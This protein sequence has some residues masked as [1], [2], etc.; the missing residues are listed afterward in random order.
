MP[1][2][3]ANH[4]EGVIMEIADNG[5]TAPQLCRPPVPLVIIAE[6]AIVHHG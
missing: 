3:I 1:L 2:D 6:G 5:R 4:K